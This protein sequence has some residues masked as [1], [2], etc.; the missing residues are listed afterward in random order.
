[1]E[2]TTPTSPLTESPYPSALTPVAGTLSQ[3]QLS[4]VSTSRSLNLSLVTAEGDKVTLSTSAQAAA[5]YANVES[6][7]VG[8]NGDYYHRQEELSAAGYQFDLDFSVEGDLNADEQREIQQV[9]QSLNKMMHQ[10]I[11]GNQLPD[12][13]GIEKLSGMETIAS[14]DARLSYESSVM[15]ARQTSAAVVYDRNGAVTTGSGNMS[16]MLASP[17]RQTTQTD[18]MADD[19]ARKFQAA[20]APW[21]HKLRAVNH[22]F[23]A[24]KERTAS[25][26]GTRGAARMDRLHRRFKAVLE[27]LGEEGTDRVDD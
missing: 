19:M 22:L 5:V 16:A 27:S 23:A 2:L 25:E 21:R 8:E 7:V 18:S 12:S 6:T 24:H 14:L 15:T 9:V 11:N 4:A 1:M 26:N 3:S 20:K 17:D 13:A 10:Y